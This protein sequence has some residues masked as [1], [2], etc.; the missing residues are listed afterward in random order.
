M[1]KRKPKLA[2]PENVAG[3]VTGKMKEYY[4]HVTKGIDDMKGY[5]AKIEMMSAEENGIPQHRQLCTS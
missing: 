3:L 4:K 1:G 2:I 5:H